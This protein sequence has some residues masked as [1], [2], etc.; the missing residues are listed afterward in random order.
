M[1]A[2]FLL[3]VANTQLTLLKD[4]IWKHMT[5]LTPM[6]RIWFIVNIIPQGTVLPYG[7]V[8]DLAGLP[9]R[10]RYVSRALKLAP[11]T[12][13]LPWHRVINSQ[14]RISFAKNTE[15]FQTQQELLRLEGI[16]VNVGK[17]SLSQYQWKPDLAT[18]VMT[19]PF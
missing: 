13:A 11:E 9:G 15:P 3:S 10:A 19:L 2:I 4:A 7:I 16:T 6:E 12:L 14:G 18:L 17:V 8:A 1:A 5:K